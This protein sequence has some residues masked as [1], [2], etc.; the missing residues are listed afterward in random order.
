MIF[1]VPPNNIAT[2]FA[3]SLIFSLLLGNANIMRISNNLLENSGK[4]VRTIDKLLKDKY[5]RLYENNFFVFYDKSHEV[6]LKLNSI[7]DG[8]MIWG[9]NET[10][11]YFK[12]IAPNHIQKIFSFMTDIRFV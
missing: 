10:V 1:H 3:Y 9:S 12:K 6:N 8:R 5:E 2:N 7:C 4:L 11:K